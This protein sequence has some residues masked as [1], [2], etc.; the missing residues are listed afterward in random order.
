MYWDSSGVYIC[1]SIV[2]DLRHGNFICKSEGKLP[3]IRT[4][5]WNSSGVYICKSI[6]NDLRH[7]NFICKSEGK[8]PSQSTTSSTDFWGVVFSRRPC[9]FFTVIIKAL[10]TELTST[11]HK[12]GKI[13]FHKS[14][15]PDSFVSKSER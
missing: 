6:V 9:G 2:N 13:F 8:L 1:Q 5:Y 14:I 10:S 4:S 3:D 11:E 12:V 15:A 7:G